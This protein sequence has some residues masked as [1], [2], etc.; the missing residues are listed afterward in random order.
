M[1]PDR[2][3]GVHPP[4]LRT[5]QRAARELFLRL[6]A[7]G[8]GTEDT[9]RRLHRSELDLP[10]SDLEAVLDALSMARLIVLDRDTVEIARE[11][12]IRAWPRLRD[13]LDAD[14]DGLRLH[15][16][17]TGDASDWAD[18]DRDPGTLYR[19]LRLAAA[20][21]WAQDAD[22]GLTT[23]EREFLDASRA[24]EAREHARRRR[25]GRAAGRRGRR[26]V[27][28]PAAARTRPRTG[29]HRHVTATRHGWAFC[30]VTDEQTTAE[31]VTSYVTGGPEQLLEAITRITLFETDAQT[32][33]E[34]EP[35]VYRWFFHRRLNA[36][37]IRLVHAVDLTAPQHAGTLIWHSQRRRSPRRRSGR[38]TPSSRTWARSATKLSGAVPF[39]GTNSKHFERPGAQSESATIRLRPEQPRRHAAPHEVVRRR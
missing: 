29:T 8:E 5:Q 1:G 28:R 18:L 22:V 26:R 32:E 12:L 15:R 27:R 33:F 24:T 3:D 13:W 30:S 19:G 4:Q 16:R 10:D 17:L 39:P 25:F 9:K 38:S 20:C 7:L 14:R 11:A 6:T 36:V 23:R 37:A 2:R 34:A 21:D 31:A 35:D